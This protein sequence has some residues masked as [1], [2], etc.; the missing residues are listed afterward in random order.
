MLKKIA[1]LGLFLVMLLAGCGGGDQVL[2]EADAQAF[3]DQV[4]PTTENLLTGLSNQDE[5]AYTRDMVQKMK[6]VSTGE[7]FTQVYNSIIGKIGKYVSA[8][9]QQVVERD[10]YRSVI[11]TAKFEDE[12][13]VTVRVVYDISGSTPMVAGLWLD[14]PKLRQK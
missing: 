11:Y 5:A 2:P 13:K 6:D 1:F 9:M 10:I 3:A 7:Q 12:E 4:A 14:S 8:E